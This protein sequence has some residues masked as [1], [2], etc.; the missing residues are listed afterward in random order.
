[1]SDLL[2]LIYPSCGADTKQA[3]HDFLLKYTTATHPKSAFIQNQ[4][5]FKDKNKNSK[6]RKLD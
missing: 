2:F 4:K 6:T 3:K 1:M 5:E